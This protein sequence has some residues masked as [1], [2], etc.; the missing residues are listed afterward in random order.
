MN[1]RS[2]LKV[3]SIDSSWPSL[4]CFPQWQSALFL[5]L[6]LGSSPMSAQVVGAIRW[7][8]SVSGGVSSAPAVGPDGTVYISTD[9]GGIY[10]MDAGTGQ[11]KWQTSVVGGHFTSPIIGLDGLVYVAGR[12]RDTTISFIYPVSALEGATGAMRWLF[13]STAG[14]E[15]PPALGV[16]GTLYLS[17]RTPSQ[18]VAV[19]SQSGVL[20][21][22]IQPGG[23]TAIGVDG[24][25]FL[26]G[27]DGHLSSLNTSTGQKLW[28]AQVGGQSPSWLVMGADGTVYD[29]AADQ[30]A[31]AFDGSTGKLKWYWPLMAP[32]TSQ[33]AIGLDGSLLIPMGAGGLAALDGVTGVPHWTI[34][35][36]GNLNST[37]AVGSDGTIYASASDGKVYALSPENGARKWWV[38]VGMPSSSSPILLADGTLVVGVA[39]GQ[40]VAVETGSP[41]PAHSA[42]PMFGQNSRHTGVGITLS[43]PLPAR[44][45]PQVVNGFVVGGT[46][47]DGGSGYTVAPEVTISDPVGTGAKAIAT[48]ANGSVT[49]I[50]ILNPGFGYSPMTV[51]TLAP[52][53]SPPRAATAFAQWGL[54]GTIIGVILTEGGSGYSTSPAVQLVGGG[55]TGATAV[56]T[57]VNG[58]VTAITLRNPGKGYTSAP[59]VK[60]ALPPVDPTLGVAVSRIKLDLHLILGAR[61]QVQSSVDLSRWVAE[62]GPFVAV[63]GQL[64]REFPVGSVPQY[65]RVIPAP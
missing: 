46:V 30:T 44:V 27:T 36:D 60:I 47:S 45:V 54:S 61:Y 63:D 58:V 52:P 41:G 24:S 50:R 64:D 10:A 35:F 22:T 43:R 56:A 39:N 55:G 3:P 5:S 57:V 13:D 65:Y 32:P 34:R 29:T 37:P 6:V 14:V 33:M 12:D 31:Y 42:W 53:P 19:D 2:M 17:V 4:D 59:T 18:L 23:T 15:L 1:F 16:D 25:L 7:Q 40:V 28:D 20:R 26:A 21:W 11:I 62:G 49:G 8:T 51:L 38:S 48:V 9:T